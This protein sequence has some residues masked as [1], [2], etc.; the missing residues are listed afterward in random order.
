MGEGTLA[1]CG[2]GVIGGRG[3][4]GVTGGVVEKGGR[5]R[6]REGVVKDGGGGG[7]ANLRL[8]YDRLWCDVV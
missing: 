5:G 7:G 1:V 4:E 3:V 6:R 8:V 2:G